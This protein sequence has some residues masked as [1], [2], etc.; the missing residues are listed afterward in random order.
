MNTNNELLTFEEISLRLREA[1]YALETMYW[2]DVDLDQLNNEFGLGPI[3]IV[4][5]HVNS[6]YPDADVGD[7]QGCMTVW[8]FEAHDIYIAFKGW[9][10]SW[11]DTLIDSI[12]QVE[13]YEVTI[14]KYKTIKQ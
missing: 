3:R 6:E 2:G 13:P 12:E 4:H 8:Y 11:D 1:G 9:Y 14:T 5:V 7:G 10:S